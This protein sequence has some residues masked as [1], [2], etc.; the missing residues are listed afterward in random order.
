MGVLFKTHSQFVSGLVQ[1]LRTEI[2]PACFSATEQK[3]FKVALFILDDMIE[4]LGPTYFSPEDF[5]QIV[6]AI[7][8]FCSHQSA[9]LRQ[10][11][12]YGIGVI[13]QNAGDA[14]QSCS[15]LCLTSLKAGI[16]FAVTPKIQGK[17]E[18]MTMYHHAR[19]NAIASIGKVIK[20]QNAVVQNNPSY[21]TQL[22]TYWLGLLPITHDIEEAIAQYEYLSDFLAEQPGF[23]LGSDPAN[24]AQ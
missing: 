24:M 8:G 5:Q 6:A 18:K 2:I 11:S 7:C 22:V 19:D 21:G 1:R 12:A 13:A 23:I 9:S 4:H 14:F 16:D 20:F 10:A 15:D 3:R 17:K